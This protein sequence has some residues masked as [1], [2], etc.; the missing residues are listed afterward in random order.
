MSAL[1]LVLVAAI[2]A[3]GL[4]PPYRDAQR[5]RALARRFNPDALAAPRWRAPQRGQ[6]ALAAVAIVATLLAG[7]FG[8]PMWAAP[9]AGVAAGWAALRVWRARQHKLASERFAADFPDAV[10]ALTRAVQAGVPIE[11]ALAGLAELFPGELGTRFAGL[12]RQLDL[13][14]PLRDALGELSRGLTLPDL[15]FFCAALLLNRDSGGQLSTM[16]AALARTLRARHAAQR[17]LSALTAE[18][19]AAARIV[20][21]MPVVILGLQAFT[22]PEHLQFLLRDAS[23]RLV[24]AYAITSIVGGLLLIRRMS[25]F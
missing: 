16:L 24:A 12:A 15:D 5:R 10:E 22:H 3:L 11:R 14:L 13:G 20:A 9:L 8:L 4:W 25:R 18:S 17:K 23:G 7:G 2:A 1:E 21:A 6:L 19:R